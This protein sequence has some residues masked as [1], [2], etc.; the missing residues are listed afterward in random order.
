MKSELC[1]RPPSSWD[2]RQS[3]CCTFLPLPVDLF[4]GD[5]SSE[6]DKRPKSLVLSDWLSVAGQ[7]IDLGVVISADKGN[8][9]VTS[10]NT[11]R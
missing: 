9:I 3:N 1:G 7:R 5:Y 11:L 6:P 2:G 4:R 10:T 8:H